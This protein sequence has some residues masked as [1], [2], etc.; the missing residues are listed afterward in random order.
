MSSLSDALVAFV[1]AA[2]LIVGGYQVY[3]IPQRRPARRARTLPTSLDDRIPFWPKWVWVY[4]VLYYPFITSTIL[5]LTNFRQ[6]AYTAA[7]FIVLLVAQVLIAYCMPVRTPDPWRQRSRSSPSEKLLGYVQS[8]DRG[9]NC[10]PSMH[11]AVATLSA[12]HIANNLSP[13]LGQLS[14]TVF[15]APLLIGASAL[16]TKQHYFVDLPGGVALAI[17]SYTLYPLFYS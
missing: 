1:L 2:V 17:A 16:F 14:D 15:V 4:S 10:F 7:D 8:I 6:F 3:F 13:H 11:M 9:G 5:T 12:L